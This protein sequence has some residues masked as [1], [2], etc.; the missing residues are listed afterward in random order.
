MNIVFWS[1]GKP[2]EERI[3]AALGHA[4]R[5]G[6]DKYERRA[7]EDYGEPAGDV[8]CVFG[9]KGIARRLLDDYRVAGKRTLFFDKGHTRHKVNGETLWRVSVDGYMPLDYFQREPRSDDRARAL[10]LAFAPRRFGEC[11]LFAGASQK[12]CDFH[13]LGDCTAHARGV[14]AQIRAHTD[15][16]IIYRPKPSWRDAVPVEG[17]DFSRPPITLA[18]E[19]RSCFVL[20]THSSNAAVD[21]ILAGVPAIVLGPGIAR[22]VASR[23][24]AEVEDPFW[25]PAEIRRQWLADLAY[26][27]WTV[28]DMATGEMWRI[29][30]RRLEA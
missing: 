17:A 27:Q 23:R 21:A 22:P 15:R 14:I 11:V 5:R 2:R 1:A 6:G 30:R 4:V 8:G 29:T 13:G 18:D 26:C 25:P 24:I 10:G 20:V 28:E 19:L 16:P 7:V 9:V 3:A 12:H